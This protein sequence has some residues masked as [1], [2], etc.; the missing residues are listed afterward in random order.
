MVGVELIGKAA[1]ASPEVSSLLWRNL[2]SANGGGD[3]IRT[4][5]T[6]LTYACFQDRCLRPLGHPSVRDA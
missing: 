3:G 6:R 4:H 5:D 1:N 2:I